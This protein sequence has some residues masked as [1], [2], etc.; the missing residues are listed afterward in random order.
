VLCNTC[1]LFKIRSP[2]SGPIEQS[3]SMQS[4]RKIADNRIVLF[5]SQLPLHLWT[6]IRQRDATHEAVVKLCQSQ[7]EPVSRDLLPTAPPPVAASD[8]VRMTREERMRALGCMGRALV[9]YE[10]AHGAGMPGALSYAAAQKMMA[11]MMKRDAAARAELSCNHLFT[12]SSKT[13][14]VAP[15]LSLSPDLLT[16]SMPSSRSC[17]NAWARSDRGVGAGCGVV[18]W[19]VQLSKGDGVC[20]FKIGVASETFDGYTEYAPKQSWVLW[21]YCTV[22][23]GQQQLT[24]PSYCFTAG[25]V[26]TV[27]LERAPGVD[28]VLRVRVAGKAPRELRGLPKEGMLYPIVCICNS[29]QSIRMEPLPRRLISQQFL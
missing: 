21:N 2:D 26:V 24:F 19:A 9:I 5:S 7:G 8:E 15:N 3:T 22:A 1:H 16:V 12:F 17:W 28:G 18:R 13:S 10:L 4:L 29:Q 20:L 25:D 27:E 11:A 23:D 6:A 14:H